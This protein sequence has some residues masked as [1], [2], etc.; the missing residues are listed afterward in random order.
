ME[1]NSN[2]S[3]QVAIA[4]PPRHRS[5]TRTASTNSTSTTHG[6]RAEECASGATTPSTVSGAIAAPQ[7]SQLMPETTDVQAKKR[8][9]LSSSGSSSDD[10]FD[11]D[12]SPPWQSP[13]DLPERR[14]MVQRIIA[15]TDKKRTT[16][17]GTPTPEQQ[18]QAAATLAKRIELSLY[19]RASS[20]DEYTNLSTLHRRLQSLVSL[21]CHEAAATRSLE[22]VLLSPKR[23]FPSRNL[24]LM[25]STPP[26][27]TSKRRRLAAL[28]SSQS[29]E[30]SSRIFPGIGDDCVRA[31]FAFLDGREVVANRVLNRVAADVLPSCVVR[32]TLHVQQLKRCLESENLDLHKL[33]NL[34]ELVVYDQTVIG[35]ATPRDVPLHAY[36]CTG[37]APGQRNDGEHVVLQLAAA[38]IAG[39]GR[40][41]RQLHLVSV[42]SNTSRCN[43]LR[44]LCD[45]LAHGAC[46]ELEDLLL[47]GSSSMD[48]GAADVARLLKS[49]GVPALVRLDL[50]RNYIGEAGLERLVA[51]LALG[52]APKLRHLCLGGNILTDTCVAPLTELLAGGACPHLRFLGLED[53]FLSPD[54]VQRIIAAATANGMAP[55]LHRVSMTPTQW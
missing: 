15:I 14:C 22:H 50:R 54:G 28:S 44:S 32:L 53:N 2:D 7:W 4:M 21:S 1:A 52:H 34:Q 12:V 38:L 36:G 51:A 3:V 40:R 16:T 48:T 31:I 35:V 10:D 20:L 23:R 41:L 33:P 13:D 43:A 19:A 6:T 17:A 29:E 47:G 30:S 25:A 39:A 26:A 18:Q 45:T 27:F 11:D 9:D 5:R 37:L 49:R 42:F 8:I 46:P 24:N 55:M